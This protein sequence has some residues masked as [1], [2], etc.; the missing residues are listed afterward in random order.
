MHASTHFCA[1]MRTH[2]SMQRR[3]RNVRVEASADKH[4]HKKLT[5][6]LTALS[7]RQSNSGNKN[8]L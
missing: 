3:A 8:T 1:R 5:T 6:G 4:R 2:T 7:R